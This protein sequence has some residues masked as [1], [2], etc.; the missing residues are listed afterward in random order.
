VSE[1]D[2][3]VSL[4]SSDEVPAFGTRD[5]MNAWAEMLSKVGQRNSQLF[6]FLARSVPSQPEERGP[7][8][9]NHST[10]LE[11]LE[12]ERSRIARDLHAGAGQPLAGI[13]M[14][15][16]MLGHCADDLPE[17]GRQALERLQ[18]LAAQAMDQVRAVSHKLHPP[19]WQLLSVED[20]IRRLVQA[21]GISECIQV[22]LDIKPLAVTPDHVV[23]IAVYRCTQECIANILKHSGATELRIALAEKDGRIELIV[24]DNGRGLQPASSSAKGIG[25]IALREHAETLG[26]TCDIVSNAH[27]VTV[28]VRL[29]LQEE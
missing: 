23:K 17:P 14:N 7:R 29:P 21:S 8:R 13:K 19:E 11:E 16:E 5:E 15:L 27:G 18:V 25:L 4:I 28:V 2:L 12:R 1:R 22:T 24:A 26:G 20:A 10:V 3:Q 9:Q 6:D